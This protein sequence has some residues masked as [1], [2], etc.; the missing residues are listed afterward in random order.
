MKHLIVIVLLVLV[1]K[2]HA[3]PY[4]DCG[5]LNDTECYDWHEFRNQTGRYEGTFNIKRANCRVDSKPFNFWMNLRATEKIWQGGLAE[6]GIHGPSTIGE[7]GGYQYPSYFSDGEF[8]S[9][10]VGNSNTT[11]YGIY[12]GCTA[13]RS[14]SWQYRGPKSIRATY[15]FGITCFG[16][17]LCKAE[18]RGTLR[19]KRP[20][21]RPKLPP[22]H[23]Y[24]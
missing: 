5:D 2:A 3:A 19:Y 12:T 6:N 13:A 7:I 10:S 21:K 17:E 15:D 20:S 24:E 23:S 8:T 11:N 16:L 1:S 14:I 22:P 18:F 4:P 9:F